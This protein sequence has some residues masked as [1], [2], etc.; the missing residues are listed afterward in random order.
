[1]DFIDIVTCISL[2][3][4]VAHF[5]YT[6][7]SDRQKLSKFKIA[8]KVDTQSLLH[9]EFKVNIVISCIRLSIQHTYLELH[10][11]L[12]VS[13]FKKGSPQ[14]RYSIDCNYSMNDDSVIRNNSRYVVSISGSNFYEELLKPKIHL[15]V[16]TAV[17]EKELFIPKNE[18]KKICKEYKKW[19]MRVT[20]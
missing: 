14:R 6:I 2:I 4:V 18:V 3:V 12:Y 15:W 10:R 7:Y 9:N 20:D 1:M 16:K 8:M 11:N 5:G 17:D 13:E 19:K